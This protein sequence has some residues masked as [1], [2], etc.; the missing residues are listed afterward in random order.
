MKLARP[1]SLLS[2]KIMLANSQ[3]SL[4]EFAE[5]LYPGMYNSD[6]AV[7]VTSQVG[8]AQQMTINFSNQNL[9]V[10]LPGWKDISL[11]RPGFV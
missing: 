5:Q 7:Q 3:K 8:D 6:F 2:V 1:S 10:E 11:I 9:M 4:N